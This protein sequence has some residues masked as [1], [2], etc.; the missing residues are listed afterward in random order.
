MGIKANMLCRLCETPIE[1]PP[2]KCRYCGKQFHELC[3]P[4]HLPLCPAKRGIP[5]PLERPM[6]DEDRPSHDD[7]LR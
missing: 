3:L 4:R 5:R 2:V 1:G 7:L 6:G